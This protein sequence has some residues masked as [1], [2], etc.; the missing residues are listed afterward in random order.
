MVLSPCTPCW[1]NRSYSSRM[2]SSLLM[3]HA[4]HNPCIMHITYFR[5]Q[6][7]ASYVGGVL[8]C[9]WRVEEPQH[10]L[11]MKRLHWPCRPCNMVCL[12]KCYIT[13]LDEVL[14]KDRH[15]HESS[16]QAHAK[17]MMSGRTLIVLLR[18][19]YQAYQAVQAW[20]AFVEVIT[21]R[22]ASKAS[23]CCSTS[24]SLVR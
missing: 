24:L 9:R 16:C 7:Q 11:I 15:C 2:H 20:C 19:M 17:L 14:W 3:L 4:M 5:S 18:S 23:L 22:V 12:R 10:Q 21:S 13:A 8:R 1:H 6:P